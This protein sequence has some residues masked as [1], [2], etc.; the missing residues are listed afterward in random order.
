[1]IVHAGKGPVYISSL[2][3]NAHDYLDQT[4]NEVFRLVAKEIE[5]STLDQVYDNVLIHYE[6]YLKTIS[7]LSEINEDNCK[8]IYRD[9]MKLR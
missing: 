9:N 8:L 1:M 3:E 2:V 5:C 4:M 7:S 6:D